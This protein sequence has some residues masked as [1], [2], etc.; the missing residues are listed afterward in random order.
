M[1]RGINFAWYLDIWITHLRLDE[2]LFWR[3]M[4]P[5]RCMA[6]YREHFRLASP[7]RHRAIPESA[8]PRPSLSQFFMGGG[9]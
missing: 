5:A 4:T 7:D 3:T 1:S 2:Q 6:I 9:R 8:G